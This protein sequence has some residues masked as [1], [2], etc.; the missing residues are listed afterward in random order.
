M[1]GKTL[2]ALLLLAFA[3][4]LAGCQGEEQ[5]P[6][7]TPTPPLE[8]QARQD[9]A[10]LSTDA[11]L[12]LTFPGVALTPPPPED[13]L[14]IYVV[15]DDPSWRIQMLG[16]LIDHFTR[17]DQPQLAAF[18]YLHG[19]ATDDEAPPRSQILELPQG[20]FMALIE[21]DSRNR[22]TLAGLSLLDSSAAEFLE[23]APALE[24]DLRPFRQGL[25][26][27]APEGLMSP[28][29]AVDTD[30]DG[31]EELVLLDAGLSEGIGATF[32]LTFR[33]TGSNLHW[34]RV[35]PPLEGTSADLPTQAVLDYLA[36]VAAATATAEPWQDLQRFLVWQWL[37]DSDEPISEELLREVADD[38]SEAALA[39]AHRKLEATRELFSEAYN[40]FSADRQNLQ[41]WP[42]F[43]NGFRSTTGAELEEIL[44][45]TIEDQKAS[46]QVVII[47]FSREGPD[48][49]QRRFRVTYELVRSED[50]WRLNEVDAKEE[51]PSE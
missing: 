28:A 6:T 16:R 37:T 19:P 50:G 4:I 11:L 48:L 15:K 13:P 30:N 17:R 1:R 26:N 22:P 20:L 21:L 5:K 29:L 27:L 25:D 51:R 32:Y 36:A 35:A 12:S 47:A 38:D 39:A 40:L 23:T 2:A 45:P 8:A 9:L 3:A 34:Q 10:Q 18:L 43:I 46:V 24:Q 14:A 49:V 33:W 31:L 44:P 41:P 42:D 7:P